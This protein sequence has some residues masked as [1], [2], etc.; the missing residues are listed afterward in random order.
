MEGALLRLA[1]PVKVHINFSDLLF[2]ISLGNT[3]VGLLSTIGGYTSRG[4]AGAGPS[5]FGSRG[6]V[7]VPPRHGGAMVT[8][9]FNVN[10][11]V[12]PGTNPRQ[13]AAEIQR[14][15]LTLKRSRGGAA[16]NLA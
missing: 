7:P 15:L 6:S 12:G 11:T 8:H 16:L 10:V 14:I 4:L 1:H 9:N 13:A 2:G 5:Y 3:L